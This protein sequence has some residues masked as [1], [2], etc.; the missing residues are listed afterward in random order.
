MNWFTDEEE[1]RQVPDA[2]ESVQWRDGVSRPRLLPSPKD[3]ETSVSR[4]GSEP[5]ESLWAIGLEAG[6]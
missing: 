1:S 5:L 4:H 2:K 3:R 6:G